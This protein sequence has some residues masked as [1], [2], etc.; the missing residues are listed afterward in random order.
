MKTVCFICTGNTCRSPMAEGLF[1]LYLQNRHMDFVTVKSAGL[2][3]A[4]GMPPSDN[5]VSAA[6]E[7]GTDISAHR[8]KALTPYDFTDDA[9]FVCMTAEHAAI[10]RQYV[11][12]ERIFVLNI[13]DPFMG[14]EHIY[15]LCAESIQEKLPSVFRFVFGIDA[16]K[17]MQAEDVKGISDIEKACFSHPWTKENLTEE[18]CNP[19]ARFFVAVKDGT[20]IGYIGANN[21]ADEVYITNI[22]VLPKNREQGIGALLLQI[23][24]TFSEKEKANFIT[25]EVRESNAP[26]VALYEKY[27]F[28]PV[29]KRKNF[30]RD[31]QEDAVIYT[32]YFTDRKE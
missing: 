10:L 31:P 3:A 24:T 29:G 32:K 20:A 11:P 2:A 27:G 9:Y 16:I 4:C 23:L 30:Y 1:R 14:D 7:L 19:T 17:P 22:A 21:I 5:A 8:S 13:P 18:L 26:A 6:R 15:R 12:H 28:Q 25:L